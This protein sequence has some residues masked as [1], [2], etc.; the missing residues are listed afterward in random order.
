MFIRLLIF[1]GSLATKCVPLNNELYMIS[2]THI[3][4]NSVEL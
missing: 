3:D 2:P 1:S 4:S